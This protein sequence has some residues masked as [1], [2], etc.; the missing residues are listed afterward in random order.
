MVG[1]T[2]KVISKLMALRLRTV[3]PHLVRRTQ[4][5][6]VAGR[7]ILNGALVANEIIN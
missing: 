5:A 6:F 7:H 1:S 3:F 4:S 2:Y